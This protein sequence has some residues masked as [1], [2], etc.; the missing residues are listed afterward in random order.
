MFRSIGFVGPLLKRVDPLLLKMSN[1]MPV[2]PLFERP[3]NNFRP[4]QA[5]RFRNSI[6]S[7]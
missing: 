3:P 4:V 7:L 5:E 1:G 6:N 2:D